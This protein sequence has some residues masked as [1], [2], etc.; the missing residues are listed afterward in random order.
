MSQNKEGQKIFQLHRFL[1]TFS[2]L[3]AVK[4]Y[5]K[6][7]ADGNFLG[8]SYFEPALVTSQLFCFEENMFKKKTIGQ[9]LERVKY[10]KEMQPKAKTSRKLFS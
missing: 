6:N 3:P 5:S 10:F 4:K 1:N 7:S 2:Q 9:S 8:P